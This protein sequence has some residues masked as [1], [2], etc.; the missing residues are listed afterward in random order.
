MAH[1]PNARAFWLLLRGEGTA[2]PVSCC[3]TGSA[4][5]VLPACR[6][7]IGVDGARRPPVSRPA[8]LPT[9]Q[10]S[11]DSIS[12]SQPTVFSVTRAQDVQCNAKELTAT[13]P[14]G[15]EKLCY[16]T[17]RGDYPDL[18]P[19]TPCVRAYLRELRGR[20]LDADGTV[21]LT[22]LEVETMLGGT[23]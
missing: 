3:A 2:P 16:T 22:M 8:P 17:D 11:D 13:Q 4:H 6:Q 20:G 7:C 18:A 9:V 23:V 12:A 21:P 19:K 1:A 10:C 5:R 15:D 14:L